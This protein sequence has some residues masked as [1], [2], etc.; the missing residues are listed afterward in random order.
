MKLAF[1]CDTFGLEMR[2]NNVSLMAELVF[3]IF[4][5]KLDG[6]ESGVQIMKVE[7]DHM[8]ILHGEEEIDEE[9]RMSFLPGSQLKQVMSAHVGCKNSVV[10]DAKMYE[11]FVSE[12]KG[13][14]VSS[15]ERR[16]HIKIVIQMNP[17]DDRGYGGDMTIDV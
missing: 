11:D 8:L 13:K 14:K 5:F 1:E 12:V 4:A 6:L 7:I 3:V 10:D 2:Q 15:A 17:I 16:K 9:T